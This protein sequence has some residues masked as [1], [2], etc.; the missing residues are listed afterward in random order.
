MND[1]LRH[2]FWH[3]GTASMT[4]HPRHP[5]QRKAACEIGLC[6]PFEKRI[7]EATFTDEPILLGG[8]NLLWTLELGEQSLVLC[9]RELMLARGARLEGTVRL[10]ALSLFGFVIRFPISG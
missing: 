3:Q 10:F 4:R 2:F 8:F 1:R 5:A 7:G 6:L 9:Q